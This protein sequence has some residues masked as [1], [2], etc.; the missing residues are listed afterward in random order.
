MQVNFASEKCSL[1]VGQ[2][3]NGATAISLESVPDGSPVAVAT[4]NVE[5]NPLEEFFIDLYHSHIL[6][7]D[8][9]ENVGM[10]SALVEANV[11][12]EL[13]VGWVSS[14]YVE[15]PCHRLTDDFMSWW[16]QGALDRQLER[17]S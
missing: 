2:Y 8:Y 15:I 7:K 1:S 10:V 3:R 6:V 14:G 9:S 5:D 4:V 11:I 16:D 17:L 12:H 13:P